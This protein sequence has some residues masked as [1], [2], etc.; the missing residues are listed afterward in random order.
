MLLGWVLNRAFA[1]I[2]PP[3]LRVNV[4]SLFEFSNWL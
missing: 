2:S 3:V 4:E 1:P